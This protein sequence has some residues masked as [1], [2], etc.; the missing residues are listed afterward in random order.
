ARGYQPSGT[1][2]LDRVDACLPSSRL[3][4]TRALH[5]HDWLPCSRGIRDLDRSLGSLCGPPR[6]PPT[7]CD[8]CGRVHEHARRP[9]AVALA[10]PVEFSDRGTLGARVIRGSRHPFQPPF[11]S[12]SWLAPVTPLNTPPRKNDPLALGGRVY[13]CRIVIRDHEA[14]RLSDAGHV[15]LTHL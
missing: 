9:G 6:V 4:C 5:L 2:E 11:V 10:G 13:R 15:S 12:S 14:R 8:G 3:R 7:P 1:D